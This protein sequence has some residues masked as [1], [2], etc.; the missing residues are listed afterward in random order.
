MKKINFLPFSIVILLMPFASHA[1]AEAKKD[2][3]VETKHVDTKKETNVFNITISPP[4]TVNPVFQPSF[5]QKNEQNNPQTVNQTVKQTNKQETKQQFSFSFQY[6]ITL[7]QVIK[8]HIKETVDKSSSFLQSNKRMLIGLGIA[9]SY[10]CLCLKIIQVNRY[11]GDPALWSSWKQEYSLPA[12]LAIPQKEIA[13]ALLH[14]IQKRYLNST[15][16]AD[17]ISPLIHFVYAIDQEMTTIQSYSY[18]YTWLKRLRLT[19]I[20]PINTKR[21]EHIQGRLNRLIF[22]KNL[23]LTWAADYNI[24]HNK[25]VAEEQNYS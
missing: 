3:H 7:S 18:L 24:E 23:F 11:L 20:L 5:E 4:I 19:Y 17:F 16:P 14:D 8:T 25:Q 21:F 12:L 15:N 9:G 13:Y 1:L 10:A 6:A 2:V 22:I